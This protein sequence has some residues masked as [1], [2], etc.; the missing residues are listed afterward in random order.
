MPTPILFIGDFY[1]E[2]E[3]ERGVAFAGSR[4]HI[5]KFL[6]SQVGLDFDDCSHYCIFPFEEKQNSPFTKDKFYAAPGLEKISELGYV[7]ADFSIHLE[8]LAS[9]INSNLPNLIVTC[10]PVALACVTGKSALKRFRGSLLLSKTGHKVLPTFS[11]EH[12]FTKYSDR[13][14]LQYDLLKAVRQ[15]VFPDLR[16]ASR[17]ILINPTLEECYDF[18]QTHILPADIL[19]VDIETN[20]GTITEVGFAPNPNVALVIPFYTRRHAHGN[21]WSTA[22][23]EL[24][25]WKL[26]RKILAEKKTFGQNFA[27]D[28]KFLWRTMGITCPG[29]CDDT[30][31]LHH[32]MQPEMEKSL[33]FLASLYTMEPNWKFMRT[34]NEKEVKEG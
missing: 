13:L 14:I 34:D 3:T 7:S 26:V 12:I 24:R 5:L 6:A 22:D 29:F 11:P 20:S 17:R 4:Y 30:M 8:N 25:A 27:Y 9:Y 28:M 31:L 32:S 1:N 18:Y 16:R 23:D 15:S 2:K 21:Y 33:G 19:S 10:G